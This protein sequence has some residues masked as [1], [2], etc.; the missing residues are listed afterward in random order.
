MSRK[1]LPFSHY[2]QGFFLKKSKIPFFR[3]KKTLVS[4]DCRA[5]D[6]AG[7]LCQNSALLK[8]RHF[9][10]NHGCGTMNAFQNLVSLLAIVDNQKVKPQ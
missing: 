1:S 2:F 6:N 5:T 8:T 4:V 3:E 7:L 9:S 10:P